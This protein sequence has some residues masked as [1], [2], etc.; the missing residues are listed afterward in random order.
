MAASARTGS[1]GRAVKHDLSTRRATV[2]AV[3][4]LTVVTILDL[5]DGSLGFV[6]GIGFVLIVITVPLWVSERALFG[7]GI[8]PPCLMMS[9]I[10]I[11]AIFAPSAIDTS[12]SGGD[13][14][15]IERVLAGL[16]NQAS[17]LVIGYTGALIVIALRRLSSPRSVD[18]VGANT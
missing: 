15:L 16:L 12:A 4:A 9:A 6:F 17:A 2:L 3:C 7:P 11:I 5:L 18:A 8:L 14:T 10:V 1:P 13:P